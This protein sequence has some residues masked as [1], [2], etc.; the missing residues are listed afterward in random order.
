MHDDVVDHLGRRQHEPPVEG[1]RAARGARAPAASAGRRSGSA[2]RRPRAARPPRSASAETSSRARLRASDS[3]TASRSSPEPR[4]LAPPLLLDPRA[5]LGEH[6]LHVRAARAE[7]GTVSR[8]DVDAVL[9]E[10]RPWIEKQRRR[11]VP[12]LGLER[13][14]VAAVGAQPRTGGRLRWPS[15]GRAASGSPIGGSGSAANGH[16]GGSCSARGTLSFNWRL[17][18][19][20]PPTLRRRARA[21]PPARPEPLAVVLVARRRHRPRVAR[22]AR[23][24][25]PVCSH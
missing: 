25:A 13:I 15:G 3:L 6:A 12:R 16:C 20:Q 23:L 21:L 11:Q 22:A 14:A 8:A 1:E 10:R 5:P 17:V 4:H 18:L 2:G 7:R 24:A 9:A 19:T